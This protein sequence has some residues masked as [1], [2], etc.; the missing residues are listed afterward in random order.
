M[1][2]RKRRRYGENKW[3]GRGG[4]D[5]FH[6]FHRFLMRGERG[7]FFGRERL[8]RL[9]IRVSIFR[10]HHPGREILLDMSAYFFSIQRFNFV[11]IVKHF[12]HIVNKKTALSMRDQFWSRALGI[13]NDG[14][15]NRHSLNDN[16]TEWLFP[17]N[18]IEHPISAAK[19]IYLLLHPYWPNITDLLIVDLWHNH[20]IKIVDRLRYVLVK[21]SGKYKRSTTGL[22]SLNR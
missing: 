13:G 8:Y 5:F 15:S 9:T 12:I 11:D 18:R 22:R 1:G 2:R 7:C 20:L 19:Q 17:C 21:C 4:W 3:C 14:A 6:E 16:H 10:G